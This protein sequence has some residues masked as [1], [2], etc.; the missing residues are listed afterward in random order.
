MFLKEYAVRRYGPLPDSGRRMLTNFNLIHGPNEDGKTLTID[1]LLRLL[2]G[3]NA[4]AGF[5]AVKR[6]KET[7]EGYIILDD[8]GEVKLPE[9]GTISDLYGFSANEFGRVFVIR[10]SDL[11]IGRENDFYRTMTARLTGIRT[12][13]IEI[14]M[15]KLRELGQITPKGSLQ[16][17][18]PYKFK[19]RF[20]GVT[21]L[22]NKIG[23]LS[24]RIESEGVNRIEEDLARLNEERVAANERLN[25]YYDAS[26]RELYEKG[27]IALKRLKEAQIE[28]ARLRLFNNEDF[29][30][31]QKAE[32]ALG[33]LG[34]EKARLE[35]DLVAVKKD[36]ALA[37]NA[38]K[39]LV[40]QQKKYEREATRAAE[41]LGLLL[42]ENEKLY[43]N[44]KQWKSLT[45]SAFIKRGFAVVLALFFVTLFSSIISPVWWLI[46]PPW[47]M[48]TILVVSGLLGLAGSW[49]KIS[50]HS[51]EATLKS[52]EEKIYIEASK[53]GFS[54]NSLAEVRQ[55]CSD[56]DRLKTET[57]EKLN[58]AEK[59]L[60]W[61]QKENERIRN[62]L[63][64]NLQRIA[65][66]EDI[67]S[68]I[69]KALSL[70]SLEELRDCLDRDSRFK[71]EIR[72][73]QNLLHSHFEE[74]G[75]RTEPVQDYSYWEAK[76]E[77][78][79]SY[80]DA[81]PGVQYNQN[82]VDRLKTDLAQ[83]EL[84]ATRLMEL[85]R[86]WAEE[87][88]DIEKEFNELM[89]FDLEEYHPCQTTIDLDVI[90]EKLRW[91][92]DEQNLNL[93]ASKL[94]IS[95]FEELEGEEEEKV[96][97]LFGAES[98]V[99]SYFNE[100]TGGIYTGVY[101]QGGEHPLKVVTAD[102]RKL[103]AYKLSGGAYDQ[104]YFSIRLALGEKLLKGGR[105]FFILDDPFIKADP[106]R[107]KSMLEMLMEVCRRGWQILYFSSKGEIK[108]A[109]KDKIA[110][111]EI[112]EFSIGLGQ[113]EN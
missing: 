91:W 99:S 104:L 76:V 80:S 24:E 100:I 108:E 62:T 95:L 35:E 7:P 37:R 71:S 101:F 59:N 110:S 26:K 105:G 73:Q 86:E 47:W 5:D 12:G 8:S 20:T 32:S 16:N 81:A 51:R 89:Q 10:D 107:L 72:N 22:I 50:L 23:P 94:A 34:I 43:L 66:E 6:V 55:A 33:H 69:R 102:G 63:E 82:E 52:L 113:L 65:V 64:Q 41:R 58:E 61:F 25:S 36:L 19:D 57:E 46:S 98:P 83:Y 42:D 1:A 88:R 11:S 40:L 45:E 54:A 85:Q 90:R 109:L 77:E 4:A 21:A 56:I 31:W 92:L 74:R 79:S 38:E 87:L 39:N 78:L 60:E 111:G 15:T 70:N 67:I 14:I 68:R 27:Q 44:I 96:T 30:R 93:S 17:T 48:L 29:D 112:K 75:H 3:K 106:V 103:D 84:K 2:F 97:K 18:E 13:E 28:E 9:A 49:L 53:V